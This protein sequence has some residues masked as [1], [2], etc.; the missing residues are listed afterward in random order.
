M[1]E[2]LVQDIVESDCWDG[3]VVAHF[4]VVVEKPPEPQSAYEP[5][6]QPPPAAVTDGL[7]LVTSTSLVL[8]EQVADDDAV[9]LMEDLRDA[10]VR[11]A[12]ALV[13]GRHGLELTTC[14]GLSFKV[15]GTD[16][17]VT[18]EA[19][20]RA[21]FASSTTADFADVGYFSPP[22]PPA[23]A[24]NAIRE[25]FASAVRT[26]ELSL[27]ESTPLP[28]PVGAPRFALVGSSPASNDKSAALA[29][30]ARSVAE[31]L[32]RERANLLA[33]L[34]DVTRSSSCESVEAEEIT[35]RL[36]LVMEH[37]EESW[38]IATACSIEWRHVLSSSA[39]ARIA[40]IA[41]LHT[42]ANKLETVLP[43]GVHTSSLHEVP[44]SDGVAALLE[45]TE[46]AVR[47]NMQS[48]LTSEQLQ[49][50]DR[51]R[52]LEIEIATRDLRLENAGH[53]RTI[54]SLRSE[55]SSVRS[56]CSDLDSSCVAMGGQLAD[57]QA[58]ERTVLERA[59][60][61]EE[62]LHAQLLQA[63]AAAAEL[64]HSAS[65]ARGRRSMVASPPANIGSSSGVF[66][67]MR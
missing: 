35:Q 9:I 16:C 38:S 3:H 33:M 11:C 23:A 25:L 46:K 57:M 51:R 64:G 22:P 48:Y 2:S 24:T 1:N 67:L 15:A 62:E 6:Q 63:R 39:D 27:A 37:Q 12:P 60:K 55:L 13:G 21:Y 32:E 28:P 66:D 17:A 31:E 45:R 5:R 7:L 56:R 54:A 43:D 36:S 42:S 20:A 49:A 34:D 4:R 41:E 59:R 50:R 61:R 18:A 29:A 65:S 44:I 52:R 8:M 30:E 10:I 53:V 26:R 14:E 58:R 47:A 40:A 19:L